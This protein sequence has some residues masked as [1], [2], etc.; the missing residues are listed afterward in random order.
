MSDINNLDRYIIFYDKIVDDTTMLSSTRLLASKLRHT[1]YM[2]VGNFLNGLSDD[3]LFTLLEAADQL[4][5]N[6]EDCVHGRDVV[7][8]SE[9]LARAEGVV[10]VTD[11]DVTRRT[12]ALC[13]FLAC[14]GLARRGL[15]KVYR[16][17]MSFG[18]DMANKVIVEKLPDVDYTEFD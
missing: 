8:I 16:E 5:I 13:S 7:L 14:E 11:E 18:E 1:P 2:T 12:E 9:M 6:Q 4:F 15:V 10:N 3:E 17:R